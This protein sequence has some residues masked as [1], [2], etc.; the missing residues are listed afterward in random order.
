[1]V[2]RI[3]FGAGPKVAKGRRK[4]RRAAQALAALLTPAAALALALGC[5]G[6]AADLSWTSSFAIP[7]G[8]FSHWQVWLGAAAVLQLFSRLLN[9]YGQD[10][11]AAPS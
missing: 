11:D 6:V 10:A 2:I 4:N 5:W 1:M 7:S 8:L 3:R 9:R